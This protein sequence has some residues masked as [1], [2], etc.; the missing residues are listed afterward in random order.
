MRFDISA[1][2]SVL[3]LALLLFFPCDL[4][5]AD[6][7][8]AKARQRL[9]ADTLDAFARETP[10][11]PENKSPL[12]HLNRP[13]PVPNNTNT[14]PAPAASSRS[15][16]AL[17]AARKRNIEIALQLAAYRYNADSMWIDDWGLSNKVQKDGFLCGVYAAYTWRSP[18]SLREWKDIRQAGPWPT[19]VRVEGEYSQGRIDYDSDVSGKKKDFDS[20]NIDTRILFGYDFLTRED[21]VLLSPY[22][23]LGYVWTTD[24]AGGWVGHFYDDYAE[25]PVTKKFFYVPVGIETIRTINATLDVAL[26]LEGDIVIP[27]GKLK[28]S[29]GDIPD[30]VYIYDVDQEEIV[31]G[32]LQDSDARLKGGVGFRSSAKVVKKFDKFNLFG[33]PFFKM[34]FLKESTRSVMHAV[35]N[36]ETDYFSCDLDRNA[37]R[38]IYEP[39]NYSFFYGLRM[40][41][42]F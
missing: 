30:M 33:E 37:V 23:G 39:N 5:A 19:F 12:I 2:S 42:Q 35:G 28:Q 29:L 15:Q 22:M 8:Y 3:P 36:N 4:F 32:Y 17:T 25:F 24:K 7:E 11:P 38:P 6:T 18:D 40:G 13:S 20:R 14:G 26:K 41:I 31:P 1:V 27:G 9:I 10:P 21:G 34:W 16:D